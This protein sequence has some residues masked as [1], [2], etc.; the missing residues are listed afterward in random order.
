MLKNH[1]KIA[2]R[3]LLQNR[4]FSLINL[5]GLSLSV[6]FCLLL[7]FYIRHEQSYDQFHQKKGRLFRMEMSSMRS[8]KEPLP[9]KPFFSFLTKSDNTRNGLVF[10]LVVGPD[11]QKSFPEIRSVTRFQT[12]GD[13]L[14]KIGRQV[15]KEKDIVIADSNFFS[16]FSFPLVGGS[17]DQALRS[18][19]NI[20]ISQRAARKYFGNANA[21]GK[22]LSF[23]D[24]TVH[25]YTVAAVAAEVP[26]NSSIQFN[27]VLPLTSDEDYA[28][29]IRER[30]NH[31]SHILIIELADNV[32]RAQF[33]NKLKP[34]VNQYFV[35]PFTSEYGQYYKD[36]DFSKYQWFLRPLADCHY[37]VSSP[38]GHFTNS[39]NIYQLVCLV[40]VILLIASLNY[41]LL[42]ISNAAARSQEVGVRKILGAGR[43]TIIMQFW[44]ETQI[45]VV[46]SVIIGL[47]LSGVLLPVFNSMMGTTVVLGGLSWKEIVPAAIGLALGLGILAGYYPALI[48]SR[49]KPVSI[50]KAFRTFR[51]NPRFSRVMVVLQFTACVV[52]MLSAY[53]INRQM[54]YISHKDLGFDKDQVLMV[55]NPTWDRDFTLRTRERLRAFA[56]T[57]PYIT[58]YSGM[59]GG[60]DG[61][62]NTN[63]FRLNGEQRWRK[64]L[65]VDYDY[66]EMLGLKFVE[67]RP[68]SR[69]IA[70][71]TSSKIRPCVVNEALW[72]MLGKEAKLGEFCEPLRHTIIGVVKNYHF[73]TLG[74]QIEPEEHVLARNYEMYFMFKI[75][76]NRMSQAIAAIEKE[77]KAATGGYPFEYT[78]LDQT[79]SKMYEAESHWQSIIEA[80]CLFAIFIACMGLFGLSAVTAINRTREIGIRKVLGASVRDIFATLSSGFVVMVTIAVLIASPIAW[81]IMH[82]YLEDFA[83]RIEI[84]WWMFP[85]AGLVSLGVAM[86]TVSFQVVRAATANPVDSLRA[87]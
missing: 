22:T 46:C 37:N 45:L 4:T 28:Q 82:A 13:R 74:K 79:I 12:Q 63:G 69:A 41:V 76:G 80:S 3:N 68:F 53:V 6:A 31:M 83:Y 20:V 78:F 70:S 84:G 33:E 51:I 32:D 72:T 25:L 26:A 5:I 44:V 7:F 67:G 42:A 21:I 73:E 61:S 30:F 8:A 77:W 55:T 29:N 35:Q 43:L 18:P 10:P 66:F 19:G 56:A 47:V 24:D 71:D 36:V 81:W 65:T 27:I 85:V 86:M 40:V 16:N 15:Y 62:Y 49:M 17:L 34:W 48:L 52:L 2:W 58:H 57:Q 14:V 50:V 1:F 60:L 23:V 38:W 59:N 39:N 64:E 9:S 75:K 87:E 54:H 11:I